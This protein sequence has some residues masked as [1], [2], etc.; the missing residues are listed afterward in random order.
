MKKITTDCC[1]LCQIAGV[2]NNTPKGHFEHALKILKEQKD[3]NNEVGVSTGNGQTAAF[4]IATPNEDELKKTL[5]E[6]GFKAIHDFE[7]RKG[8]APVGMLQMY[9]K[10][11]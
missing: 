8:Y 2:S 11:F 1:A 5:E 10:N 9:I 3:A 7:R 4:V 6:V